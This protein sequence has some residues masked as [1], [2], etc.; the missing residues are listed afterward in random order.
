MLTDWATVEKKPFKIRAAK[1][2]SNVV[3]AA[4]QADVPTAIEVKK[5]RIGKRPKYADRNTVHNPPAP[6]QK[7]FPTKL[8]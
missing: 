4:H 3:A 1:Y 2:E 7:R 8:C 6:R 5:T